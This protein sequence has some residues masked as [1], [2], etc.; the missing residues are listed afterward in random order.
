[1]FPS[2]D[3]DDD[4]WGS[5]SD[6]DMKTSVGRYHRLLRHK[7][8]L[9][10]VESGEE[11]EKPASKGKKET[12]RTRRKGTRAVWLAGWLAWS[13]AGLVCLGLCINTFGTE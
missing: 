9:Y 12:K 10:E 6:V 7:L 4:E 13:L 3:D 8:T 11:K 1:L 5:G 2:T